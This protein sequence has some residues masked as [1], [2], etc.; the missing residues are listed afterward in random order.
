MFCWEMFA[1]FLVLNFDTPVE[2]LSI[3]CYGNRSVANTKIINK[4]S[5]FELFFNS[6][7][8]YFSLCCE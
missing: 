7:L 5:D 8:L 3:G 2:L 1:C 4:N 6:F